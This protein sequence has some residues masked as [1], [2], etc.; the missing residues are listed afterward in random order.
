MRWRAE[1]LLASGRFLVPAVE[2]GGVPAPTS[3][4]RTPVPQGNEVSNSSCSEVD[5]E[6]GSNSPMPFLGCVTLGQLLS[7]LLSL[8]LL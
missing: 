1:K 2:G 3:V 6:L 8:C 7:L 5:C 4:C